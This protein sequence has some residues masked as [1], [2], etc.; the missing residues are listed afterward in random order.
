MMMMVV[1]M[2][3]MIMVMMKIYQRRF[4]SQVCERDLL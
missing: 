3:V 1:M 4:R 2:M